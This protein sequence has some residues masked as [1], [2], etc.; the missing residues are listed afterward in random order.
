MVDQPTSEK[1]VQILMVEDDPLDAEL[2]IATL[3]A[4]GISQESIRVD[5]QEAFMEQL[6]QGCPDLILSDYSLPAFDGQSAL[7]LAQ[8]ACPDVPFLFVSGVIGEEIAIESLKRGATDYILKHRLDRLPL[9]VRRALAEARQRIASRLAQ[10]ELSRKARE[11]TVLNGDLQ[12][13]A[14]AA[15]HDLQ[16]PLR[17]ISIFSKLL[18]KRYR[19]ALD[20]QADEYLTFIQS[21]A[22][23][24]SALLEDLLV[25]A[26]IPADQRDAEPVDLNRVIDD[27]LFLFQ[28]AI[29][30]NKAVITREALPPVCGNAGQLALVFQNLVSNALKYRGED[31]PRIEIAAK[32]EGVNCIV[33][34]KD[35]GIGFDQQYSEQVFGLF[36]RLNNRDFPGTGLGLAICKRIVEAAGG[37]I[38]AESHN[39]AGSTFFVQLLSADELVSNANPALKG[40]S[41][42]LS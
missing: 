41:A 20:E 6:S 11:L 14:Y 13:F 39:N 23:H 2:A 29:E 5:T 42:L 4:G 12:Q 37:R 1:P 8:D 7:M 17:T 36:K 27:T 18:G 28:G 3:R 16:E 24:M 34:V 40:D 19:G 9:A 30:D 21:A 35:N 31:P 22:E 32:R 26:R 25:Y 38:W 33:S 10:E 15:S